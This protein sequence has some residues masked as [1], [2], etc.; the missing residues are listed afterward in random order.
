M[1]LA[2]L[3][4]LLPLHRNF[5]VSTGPSALDERA[6][7]YGESFVAYTRAIAAFQAK[8]PAFAGSVSAGQLAALGFQ[9]APEFL[10]IAGNAITTAGSAGRVV[11]TYAQLPAGSIGTVAELTGRDGAFGIA[12][13]ATWLSIA[14]GAA[15]QP[16]AIAVSAGSVVAVAQGG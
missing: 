14:P 9:F 4:G 13:G 5:E 12:N 10:A 2:M 7:F 1:V 6:R 11:T 15:A 16:L 3:M 8:N